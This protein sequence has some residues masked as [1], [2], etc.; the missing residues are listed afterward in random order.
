MPVALEIVSPDKLL[1]SRPVDM[2]VI[3]AGEGDIGVLPGHTPLFVLLRGGTI[4]LYDGETITDR[5]FVGG[6][7]AEIT[8]ERCTVLAN[9]VAPVA[10]L[11]RTEAEQRLAEADAELAALDPNDLVGEEMALERAQTARALIEAVEDLIG[12]GR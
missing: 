1:L 5:L 2:V 12:G 11:N 4:A 6:G 10:E 7:F 8:P 3:P 9:D